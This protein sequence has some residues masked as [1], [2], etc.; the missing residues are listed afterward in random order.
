VRTLPLLLL[1]AAL[2]APNSAEEPEI[3]IGVAVDVREVRLSCPGGL[4][5]TAT[6]GKTTV[7]EEEHREALLAVDLGE[8][9]AAAEEREAVHWKVM[10]VSDQDEARVRRVDGEMDRLLPG[11]PRELVFFDERDAWR[12]YLGEFEER[13]D[14]A[15]L[16]RKLL[17]MGYRELWITDRR[18][19]QEVVTGGGGLRLVD[20]RYASV[21]VAA[22]RVAVRP[23][24]GGRQVRV[25]GKP[26]R[27]RV[28]VLLGETGRLVVVNV[29]PMEQYL[30][31][32]V[33]V[34]MGP[35]VYP[36]LEALKAQ[37]VAARTYAWRNMGQFA[38]RGYDLCATPRCQV[39]GGASVEQPLTDR[40]V[41]LTRGEVVLWGDEPVDAYF[42]ATCGGHT[43]DVRNVFVEEPSRPYLKG[44]PCYP[45]ADGREVVRAAGSPAY[46]Y[47]PEG[48]LW[49][50][51][52]ALLAAH[53]VAGREELHS[54]WAWQ[55]VTWAEL[56]G[57]L[58][59]AAGLAGV[60][61]SGKEGEAPPGE[62]TMEGLILRAV[63]RFGWEGR[64][65]LLRPADRE[66]VLGDAATRLPE[67]TA[68]ALALLVR[69][70]VVELPTSVDAYLG[71]GPRRAEAL[72]FLARLLEWYGVLDP[73]SG[74]VKGLKGGVLEVR[75]GEGTRS[76]RLGA[77]PLLFL[78]DGSGREPAT[79]LPI[80]S[81]D[82][83]RWIE[84]DGA[85]VFL[86]LERERVGAAD[87]RFSGRYRWRKQ[88][89]REDLESHLRA[90]IGVDRLREVRPLRLTRSGRVAE[91]AVHAEEGEYLV[92][93]I[94]VR[95]A[96][97]LKETLFVVEPLEV[98]E[99]GIAEEY[100][101]VGQGWGH[102]VGLCQ[103]GSYGMA[104]RGAKHRAILSH[105]YPSTEL[106]ALW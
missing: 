95:W 21:P 14:A 34:E 85:V 103:V 28:E 7:L 64:A 68:T 59:R 51:E 94:R 75:V 70:G 3:R 101:F 63:S 67:P 55:G 38:E 30:R 24:V 6:T 104:L 76:L 106:R 25:D 42:T 82:R 20:E 62:P 87:D 46:L 53:G 93:G 54:S 39:Y 90:R 35:K 48:A 69:E 56:D 37:A 60:P 84:R 77:D 74:R 31:G 5:L 96:L 50:R 1:L 9:A 47:G 8:E 66:A 71:E 17:G 36:E 98:G 49:N 12:V 89:K 86:E 2:A 105:Y 52:I 81:G 19:P 83:V 44:V 72:R 79:V 29:L 32:V 102:G 78:A 16:A 45:E 97:G 57:W 80:K 92:R 22:D 4:L 41:R 18:R 27:G 43:E 13:E 11:V 40:A 100:L 91:L 58:G 99:D 61:P 26:Y 65:A 88:V 23:V 33:P 10:V 73:V 15:P